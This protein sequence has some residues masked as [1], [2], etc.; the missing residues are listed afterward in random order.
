[1][2]FILLSIK[3]S[4]KT[5]VFDNTEI[6]KKEFNKSK[7]AIDLNLASTNKMVISNKFRHNDDGF[8]Y[9]I[10]Y[11]QDEKCIENLLFK[12]YKMYYLTSNDWIH[13]NF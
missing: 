8:I 5:L 11:K 12:K 10:G 4:E 1:M 3:I 9:F 6:N 13:K 2:N 7:Q